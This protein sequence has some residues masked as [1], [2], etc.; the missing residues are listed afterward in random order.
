MCRKIWRVG[1]SLPP[2]LES[3]LQLARVSTLF[4]IPCKAMWTVGQLS[5]C[6][7]VPAPEAFSKLMGGSG[8]AR[9]FGQAELRACFYIMAQKNPGQV[10]HSLEPLLPLW[11][12]GRM[13]SSP[14]GLWWEWNEPRALR[15][16]EIVG[17]LIPLSL[18]FPLPKEA[19]L[20]GG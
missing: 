13:K 20:P 17:F 19:V 12:N 16:L 10:I 7:S 2:I 14:T 18:F 8:K 9:R 15:S 3:W 4:Q 6:W 5:V 1:H 11:K